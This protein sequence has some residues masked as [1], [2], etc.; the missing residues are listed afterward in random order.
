M[1]FSCTGLSPLAVGAHNISVS[2]SYGG[3]GGAR[4]TGGTTAAVAGNLNVQAAP[5]AALAASSA[6]SVCT[7]SQNIIATFTYAAGAVASSTFAATIAP[8]VGATCTRALAVACPCMHAS[9]V[10]V[11]TALLHAPCLYAPDTT[12]CLCVQPSGWL[13]PPTTPSR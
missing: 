13:A 12:C 2:A 4:C 8:Y 7:G 1:S 5:T 6:A 9:N 10:C 11:S 3:V